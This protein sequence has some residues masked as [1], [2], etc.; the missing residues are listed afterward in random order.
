MGTVVRQVRL[1]IGDPFAHALRR[2]SGASV[3]ALRSDFRFPDPHPAPGRGHPLPYDWRGDIYLNWV[4]PGRPAMKAV[5][6]G[7]EV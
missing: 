5:Q 1:V 7:A 6:P 3:Q 4:T 2:G